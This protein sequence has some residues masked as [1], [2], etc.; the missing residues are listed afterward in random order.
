MK[1]T[2]LKG[3]VSV[4]PEMELCFPVLRKM[5]IS[6]YR[7]TT[8]LYC[9]YCCCLLHCQSRSTLK[10]AVIRERTQEADAFS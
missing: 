2:L 10:E 9:Y 8:W 4:E 5:R 1:S 6:H 7:D 3:A